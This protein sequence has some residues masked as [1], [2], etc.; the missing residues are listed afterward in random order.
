MS[1]RETTNFENTPRSPAF[2]LSPVQVAF[3]VAIGIAIAVSEYVF[4]YQNVGYGIIISLVMVLVINI[5]ISVWRFDPKIVACA[6]SLTLVPLYILFTSSLPW[7]FINQQYL[8]P[9]VYSCILGLCLWH[10]YRQGLSLKRILNF[11]KGKMLKYCLIGLLIGLPMGIGEY[12]VLQPTPAFPSFEIK[13]LLR[14]TVYMLFFVG[15]AEEWLFRGLIQHD[16]NEAFGWKWALLATAAFCAVMHL[17]WRS[18]PEL[19]FVFAAGLILGA[20]WLKTKSLAAP[21]VAHAVNNVVLVAVLPYIL[22]RW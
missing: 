6:E 9:V 7:F 15:L 8:L 22:R 3:I 11:E 4:A 2:R 20:L 13:Y 10:V 12:F 14:D 21:I 18:I 5:V 17:T 16:L 19:G 1:L